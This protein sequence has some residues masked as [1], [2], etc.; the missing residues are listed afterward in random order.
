MPQA[1][2]NQQNRKH[3]HTLVGQ[4]GPKKA[5]GVICQGLDKELILELGEQIYKIVKE[6]PQ[7]INTLKGNCCLMPAKPK[8][9]Q[10]SECSHNFM[11]VIHKESE[12]HLRLKIYGSG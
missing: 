3:T 5:R 11:R 9:H 7:L 1:S 12:Y 6:T 2:L 8:Q 10:K 4:L